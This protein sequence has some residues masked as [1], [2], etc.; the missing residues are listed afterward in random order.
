MPMIQ[1]VYDAL[2]PGGIFGVIDHVGIVG[3]DNAQLHRMDL[4]AARA[5]L[6]E[7]GFAIVAE[8]DLLRNSADDHT[9][10]PNDPSLGGN[11]DRFLIK[12]QKPN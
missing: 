7:A 11:T 2:K 12:A 5:M 9:R 3:Q 8:S 4:D 6:V 1:G 10:G